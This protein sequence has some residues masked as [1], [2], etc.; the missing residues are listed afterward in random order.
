MVDTD[1][2][3]PPEVLKGGRSS[4]SHKMDVWALLVT[5]PYAL[6]MAG[7]QTLFETPGFWM[8]REF[9][10]VSIQRAAKLVVSYVSRLTFGL[11]IDYEYAQLRDMSIPQKDEAYIRFGLLEPPSISTTYAMLELSVCLGYKTSFSWHTKFGLAPHFAKPRRPRHRP[12]G[13]R[14]R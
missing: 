5:M 8:S 13:W 3:K 11:E 9:Q 4:W 10:E 12:R 7:M 2:Y 6:D 14:E 1:P